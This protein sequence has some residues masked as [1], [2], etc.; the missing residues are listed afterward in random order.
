M[1]KI[2]L[3]KD[4]NILLKDDKILEERSAPPIEVVVKGKSFPPSGQLHITTLGTNTIFIDFGDGSEIYS[5]TFTRDFIVRAPDKIHTY[6]DSTVKYKVKI[7]FEKP[8]SITKWYSSLRTYKFPEEIS[9]Y[10]NL[11]IIDVSRTEYIDNTINLGVLNLDSLSLITANKP[12]TYTEVPNYILNSNITSLTLGSEFYIENAPNDNLESLGNINNLKRLVFHDGNGVSDIPSSF[13]D[14]KISELIFG[15]GNP[16][17]SITPNINACKQ[18][19]RLGFGY[20][21]G[22]TSIGG[23]INSWGE[24]F[25]GMINLKKLSLGTCHDMPVDEIPYLE[26]AN[27]LKEFYF[28]SSTLTTERVDTLVT[29]L[30]NQVNLIASKDLGNTIMRQVFIQLDWVNVYVGVSKRPTGV[31]QEPIGYLQGSNNGTPS[32][33][34]E[35]L[36]VL[37]NQYKW[38]AR[39]PNVTEDGTEIL[40][41]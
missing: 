4:N 24:G 18:L 3:N 10:K 26:D 19:I 5:K 23:K 1:N 38:T 33:P 25:K 31:Y 27:S 35:M 20:G 13:K 7:W 29:N 14:S 9:M 28:K 41:P 2:L 16:V 32:T 22:S 12:K 21:S 11:T 8:E 37:V 36:Y 6:N 30:Y 39:I 34:M 17:L 40:T 15:G